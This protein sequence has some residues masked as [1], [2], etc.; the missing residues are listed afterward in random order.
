MEMMMRTG[1]RPDPSY[2]VNPTKN[3]LYGAGGTAELLNPPVPPHA[4]S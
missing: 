2:L 4:H 3:G 1:G